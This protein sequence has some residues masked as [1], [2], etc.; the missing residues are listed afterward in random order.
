[1]ATMEP[2]PRVEAFGH[3]ANKNASAVDLMAKGKLREALNDLNQAIAAAPSYHHSYANRAKVF[4]RMGMLPQAEADRKRAAELA[5]AAGYEEQ[6]IL[7]Q[8]YH[9]PLASAPAPPQTSPPRP[10][11]ARSLPHVTLPSLPR[12]AFPTGLLIPVAFFVLLLAV[13]AG[14]LIGA[15][16]ILRG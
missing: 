14:A 5:I 12:I 9:R 1:M 4:E 2:E 15:L 16:A 8:A 7:E 11:T 13:T 10:S 6:E 3:A